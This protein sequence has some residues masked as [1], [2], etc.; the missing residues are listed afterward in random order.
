VAE[1]YFAG[2]SALPSYYAG[3]SDDVCGAG[4]PFRRTILTDSTGYLATAVSV[5]AGGSVQAPPLEVHC[6]PVGDAVSSPNSSSSLSSAPSVNTSDPTG[7][8]FVDRFTTTHQTYYRLGQVSGHLE[9]HG[10]A[11]SLYSPVHATLSLTDSAGNTVYTQSY[12]HVYQGDSGYVDYDSELIADGLPAGNYVLHVS[13]STIG[14]SYYPAGPV[15][16]DT[17]PFLLVTGSVNAAAPVLAADLPTNARCRMDENFAAYQSPPGDPPRSSVD[18]GGTHVGFCGTIDPSSG[19][20]GGGPGPG[21]IL[22]WLLPW[23]A[24]AAGGRIMVRLASSSRRRPV[25]APSPL[26]S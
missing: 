13:A 26:H 24:M 4:Q 9:V 22:G 25:L 23:F 5:P 19:S 2:A 20:G 16:L 7:F 6:A 21:E 12:D 11:Y 3:I 15:A 18:D 1:P 17:D 8:G 10:L 14:V